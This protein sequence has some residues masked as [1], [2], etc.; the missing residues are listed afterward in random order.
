MSHNLLGRPADTSSFATYDSTKTRGEKVDEK[1]EKKSLL[2]PSS[3]PNKKEN[4]EL[5]GMVPFSRYFPGGCF[6]RLELL[7]FKC[8]S[9]VPIFGSNVVRCNSDTITTSDL[10]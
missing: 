6:L 10:K 7:P 4:L 1:Q 8:L 9:K 3:N 5:K 2:T